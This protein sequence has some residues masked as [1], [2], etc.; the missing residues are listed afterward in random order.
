MVLISQKFPKGS[1]KVPQPGALEAYF[2]GLMA[3]GFLKASQRFPTGSPTW[4]PGGILGQYYGLVFP[5]SLPKVLERL[6]N[7]APQRHTLAMIWPC[8][9]GFP[10]SFQK[11]PQRSL[12]LLPQG[13]TLAILW[14]WVLRKFPKG[15][16]QFPQPGTTGSLLG[17]IVV[18]SFLRVS[19]RFFKDP[20]TWPYHGL[21]FPRSFTKLL[22]RCLNLAPH[23]RGILWQHCGL[24]FLQVSKIFSKGFATR[25]TRGIL[26]LH[27]GGN[28]DRSRGRASML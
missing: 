27:C 26:C 24:N 14:R 10:K 7:L 15:S 8:Q 2:G 1:L 6:L 21:R 9:V 3:P 19:Q 22:P 16:S 12:N 4:R 28:A 23:L 13:H 25:H 11:V 18:S 17:D 20:S 5:K